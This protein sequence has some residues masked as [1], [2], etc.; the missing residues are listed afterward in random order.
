M[1]YYYLR[2]L[3]V[4]KRILG[5]TMSK[6]A[7]L[8]NRLTQYINAGIITETKKIAVNK[9]Q[10]IAKADAVVTK[11]VHTVLALEETATKVREQEQTKAEVKLFKLNTKVK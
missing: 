6:I 10:N 7:S 2:L 4:L 3:S 9:E 5:V 1:G 8:Y 11:A